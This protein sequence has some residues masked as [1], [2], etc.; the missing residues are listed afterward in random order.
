MSTSEVRIE[1]TPA[2]PEG[3]ISALT[4]KRTSDEPRWLVMLQGFRGGGETL[5]VV[6]VMHRRGGASG[7]GASRRHPGA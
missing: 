7:G 4:A 2:N 1:E 5:R 3:G 6:E